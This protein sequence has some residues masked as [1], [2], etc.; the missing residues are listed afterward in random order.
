[1]LFS[2]VYHIILLETPPP[3]I[4][5]TH[6]NEDQIKCL[7]LL[8]DSFN[9]S[10]FSDIDECKEEGGLEGHHCHSNTKCVNTP[11]SYVCECLP[12]YKQLDKFNCVEHDECDSGDHMC[13]ENALCINTLG[14]YHC[15]CLPGYE[16]DGYSCERK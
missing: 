5:R 13:H 11:G 10:F 9:V 12:G 1:M 14:S 15:E 3:T 6:C 8:D 2:C 16:G 7:S 4:L